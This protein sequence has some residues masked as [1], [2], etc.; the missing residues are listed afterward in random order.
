MSNQVATRNCEQ[1]VIGPC[2]PEDGQIVPAP[3]R[4][5]TS[6]AWS[7]SI[8]E[9]RASRR[10]TLRVPTQLRFQGQMWKG[11]T[12]SISLGGLSMEFA[13]EI[14]AML[15][16][17]M[18]LSLGREAA[19]VESVGMVCGIRASEDAPGL[20]TVRAKMTLAIQ[21]IHLSAADERVLA[22]LLSEGH[23]GIKELRV[24]AVL[25]AQEQEEALI[26]AGASPAPIAPARLALVRGAER[27][28]HERR[29]QPRVVVGLSTEV[30]LRN[31]AGG[32][33]CS[34]ALTT[35]LTSNG[36]CVR[37]S[38]DEDVLGSELEL[39]WTS[40]SAPQGMSGDVMPSGLCSVVGEV[41]WTKPGSA[42]ARPGCVP[43]AGRTVLAGVRF[44]PVAKQAEDVIEHL[45]A[46]VPAGGVESRSEGPS[47]ISEFSEC[48]RPSG[49]RIVLCHDRSRT[50]SVDDAPIV[51]LAPG[52]GESKRDYVPLAYYLA[53]NGFHVV[54]YDNVNHVGESDG[55]V[56]QFRLEDMET[57]LETVL[58]Y[59]AGQWPGRP[60]GLVAT[61]LAGRV[62][63]KVTGR[64]P[65][66]RLLMLINGIM[67]VR[68]T[69]QAVHQ[70]DLIG[71][72][73]GGVRKGVVNILGLTIDAD[74]WLAHA[75][76]AGYADV[77]TTQRDAER[78]RTPVVLF[79]AEQDAWVDPASIAAVAEA[80]GPNLRHSFEVPGALHRLQESPRKARTV[81]RQI[82]LCCQQELW[83]GRRQERIVEPSHREIGA[84]NR[85]ERERS[86]TRRPMRKSDHVAFWQDYLHNFQ[87]IPNVADF[88]RLMDHLY[89]LM[90]E[91][92]QGER[93]LDAGCG[94]GNFGVFL[95]LNE[96]FRQRYARRG[97][98]LSPEY[99]GLDFVPAALSQAQVN[100]EQVAAALQGQFYEGLRAYVPM[101]M[102]LCQADLESPLPFPDQSFDRVVCNLVLGYVRDPLSTLR[103]YLRVLAPHGRL[104]ISN[105]KP[106]ADLSAIYRNFVETAQTPDQIEE[107]R[108]L[109]DNS[110]RIKEREGEGTFQFHY[111][112]EFEGLLRAAGVSRPHVYSTF[113]NQALIAVADKG[114]ANVTIAA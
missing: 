112:A 12:R 97:N 71:E 70:E 20:G 93:I 13:S 40:A 51:I 79:H 113:G 105:L 11:T 59:V 73:L 101:S 43:V 114:R 49:D 103:E 19:G 91:C 60:I 6:E 37:L 99:V 21:F 78:L 3:E 89:R 7:L 88:W 17:Q 29:R 87:T 80:M 52:Y 74:R 62:A 75:V 10:L 27:P 5:K 82:A 42:D 35:D 94:N 61:S 30:S 36:A 26:E 55:L 1:V 47:V 16:Q 108:R 41:V 33:L 106:Y 50:A 24:T 96:A 92:H 4:K 81:Y 53:G 39:R 68:H 9:R 84:Q 48:A 58:D 28:R 109:L 46:Q 15:N 72:H 8:A 14:P 45:L 90:G 104:V 111:Q 69:L 95:Q 44:L 22:G 102:R 38:V 64:V 85:V 98:F 86:K 56:T 63:L 57:D 2:G 34:E 31:Q 23:T 100:F 110:G 54:R 25:V 77:A 18:M 32:R 66:V 67:D 107:G 76:Q 83:P 65:H